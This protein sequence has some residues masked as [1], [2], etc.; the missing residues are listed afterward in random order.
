MSLGRPLEVQRQKNDRLAGGKVA[1]AIVFD[2]EFTDEEKRRFFLIEA[3]EPPSPL[4][5]S[6]DGRVMRY[7]APEED[8]PK[9]RLALEIFLVKTFRQTTEVETASRQERHP[10]QARDAQLHLGWTESLVAPAGI[11]QA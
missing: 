8:E 6:F 9:W 10:H 3:V 4:E 2:R 5:F 11:E 1:C 7:I